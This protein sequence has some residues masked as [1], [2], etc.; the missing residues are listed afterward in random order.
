MGKIAELSGFGDPY[1]F[2]RAFRR[3]TG[4][5]P[6]QY[7]HQNSSPSHLERLNGK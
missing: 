5:T 2:S 7:R 6:R 1:N 3:E 4:D